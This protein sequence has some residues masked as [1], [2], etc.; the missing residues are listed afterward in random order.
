MSGKFGSTADI[1][2]GRVA[3]QEVHPSISKIGGIMRRLIKSGVPAGVAALAVVLAACGGSETPSS[4]S[5]APPTPDAAA[6]QQEERPKFSIAYPS[7]L[8]I[9]HLPLTAAIDVLRAEGYEIE[10]PFLAE[11]ELSVEGVASG[12]FEMSHGTAQSTMI[13]NQAGA[14]MRWLVERVSNEWTLFTR[15][16]IETCSD[17]DGVRLAIHSEGSVSGAMVRSYIEETCPDARPDYLIIPGS[18]NRAQALLS[19]QIDA[20]PVELSDALNLQRQAGDRFHILA[21]FSQDL[22]SLMTAT[23]YARTEFIDSYPQTVQ[24]LIDEI[25]EQHRKVYEEAGYM[26]SLIRTYLPDYDEEMLTAVA[27]QYSNGIMFPLDGGITDDK[28]NF[29]IN[30]FTQSGDVAPGLVPNDV[31]DRR[32]MS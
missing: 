17:L 25:L 24:R 18:S 4:G 10:T 26:E 3:T 20:S 7:V 11:S 16:T 28:A 1:Q 23:V 8:G 32:F 5:A 13:A 27:E 15:R 2:L 29:T 21:N 6:P 31:W 22:P 9:S 19:D 12:L 30:F 14:S